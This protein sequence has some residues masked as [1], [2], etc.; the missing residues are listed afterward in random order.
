MSFSERLMVL[1]PPLRPLWE[2][3]QTSPIAYRLAR[4]AFW[5]LV[6]TVVSR[7]L[8]LV[9]SMLVARM[10]GKEGFG[11]LG[12]IQNT[13]GMFGVFAGFG[14]GLTAT[15]HVAESR[16]SDPERAG[17]IIVFTETVTLGTSC[18]VL[19]ILALS[20][21]FLARNTLAA[22]DLTHLLMIGGILIPFSALNGVQTG[23]LSGLESFRSIAKVN[24][25]SGLL[26][27]PLIVCG[28]Y[29]WDLTGAVVG[30]IATQVINCVFSHN[31]LRSEARR[32]GISLQLAGSVR[33][34]AALLD[35]S[36]PSVIGNFVAWGANWACAAI[37]V[38]QANG[39]A[40]MG[41]VS[42]GNQWR[43]ALLLLPA[44]LLN[45][46]LPMLA[47]EHRNNNGNF[48][49]A[50]G[51]AHKTVV[52]LVLPVTIMLM[53]ASSQILSLYGSSFLE[54]RAALVYMLAAA[55]VSAISSPAGSAIIAKGKMWFSL[56]LNLSNAALF[57]ALTWW[58]APSQGAEGLSI[59]FLSGHFL[60]ALSGYIYLKPQL[61]VG[62][63]AR[64]VS[65][66]ILIC[67]FAIALLQI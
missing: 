54:G 9:S 60:Q 62:M 38:N 10:L 6:G 33:E 11:Q 18:L 14:M 51:L 56:V 57:L 3:L 64:N 53:I 2:H 61:P 22:P 49:H 25:I 58:L 23:A 67:L 21:D 40:H 37:L 47:S 17:R 45:A 28:A 5:S 29:A 16:I 44:L 66:M 35:F 13:V 46:T 59:A 27:F 4:G 42:V 52:V 48:G 50:L 12:V 43:N 26:S 55:A 30:L 63:F 39:Y 34:R 36:L 19:A 65:V 8:T 41:L 24:F 7:G 31:M 1:T 15:K 32:F 20:A